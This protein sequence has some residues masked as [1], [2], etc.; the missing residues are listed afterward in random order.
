M[1]RVA[2]QLGAEIW[3]VEYSEVN[4]DVRHPLFAGLTGHMFGTVRRAVVERADA[5]LVVGT[6]LFPEVF[7][8]L[9]SPFAP[10]TPVV[11]I[12]LNTYEI[13]KNHPVTLGLAADPRSTLEALAG[14]LDQ[15]LTGRQREDAARRVDAARR[16]REA[17]AA[18][19][20]QPASLL[21]TFAA[22]LARLAPDDLVVFDEALTSSPALTRHLPAGAPGSWFCTRGGSLGVGIPGALGLKLA[23]PDRT[24]IAF[25]GDGGSQYTI[26]AL[27]TAVRHGVNAKFVICNNHRYE[28]LN[29][30]LEHYWDER[31]IPRHEL[32]GSFD[33]A[34]PALSFV[35]LARGYGVAGIRV[36]EPD[37]VEDAVKSMLADDRPFLIDL[38]ID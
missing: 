29:E 24:V 21:E 28:L 34:V 3:G 35:D 13:A 22:T 16:R 23:H 1:L 10:G 33:L 5:V 25:T 26:Q 36:S 18:A 32:P 19:A 7:P 31:G 4:V 14:A 27:A 8:S 17:S 6:Y 12:D 37:Q 11:H 30:N 38:V 15:R 20:A 9:E 2:E